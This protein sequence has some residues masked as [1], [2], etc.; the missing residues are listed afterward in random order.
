LDCGVLVV[1]RD[2]ERV[3][4]V[5]EVKWE[6]QVVEVV[7]V[8]VEGGVREG[9]GQDCCVPGLD[10]ERERSWL[11]ARTFGT[12]ENPS[13]DPRLPDYP[14]PAYALDPYSNDPGGLWT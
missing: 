11:C 12:S 7:E 2:V 1:E 8:E 10:E 3:V 13:C 6:V 9:G 4:E 5:E 14:V